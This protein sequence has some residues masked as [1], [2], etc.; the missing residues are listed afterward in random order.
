MLLLLNSLKGMAKRKVQMISIIA[1]ILLSATIYMAMNTAITRV[2]NGYYEYL[3]TQNV[4]HFSFTPKFKNIKD[5]DFKLLTSLT[6][7][8]KQII[9]AYKACYKTECSKEIN[10]YAE[11]IFYKYNKHVFV[12]LDGIKESSEKLD[13]TYELQSSKTFKD[14]KVYTKVV[15]YVDQKI[16]LPYLV[17]GRF[18]KTNSEITILPGFKKANDIKI[19]DELKVNGKNYTVVGTAYL[20][21]HIYPLIS[22]NVPIFT[23][24]TNNIVIMNEEEYKN[25]DLKEELMYSARFN[26]DMTFK[27]R[28]Q[29][30][31]AEDGSLTIV[32]KDENINFN[33]LNI[34]RFIRTDAIQGDL[35]P[36]RVFTEAFLYLLI[37]IASFIVII[38]VKKRIEDEKQQIGILKSLGYNSFNISSSYLLYPIVG[39][40]I[41]SVLG[42]FLGILL[43]PFLINMYI[44]VYNLPIGNAPLNISELMKLIVMPLIILSIVSY[45]TAFLMVRK[46][47]LYLLKEGSNLKVNFLSRLVNKILTPFKFKTRFKYSLAFRSLGKLF[48][49]SAVSFTS[50]LL[51]VLI[52]IGSNLFSSLLDQMFSR[53]DY[54]YIVQYNSYMS[55]EDKN[56]DLVFNSS[57]NIIKINDEK[58]EKEIEISFQG[59]DQKLIYFK[60]TDENDKDLLPNL[61]GNNIIIPSGISEREE[62]KIGDVLTFDINN[63]E[64]NFKV[65]GIAEDYLSDTLYANRKTLSETYGFKDSVYTTKF[66]N[67]KK[68]ESM[69]NLTDEEKLSITNIFNF[70]DLQE[71]I[72]NQIKVFNSVIYVVIAFSSFMALIIVLVIANIVVEENKKN[73]SLMKVLGYKNK[74]I[75]KVILNIYTPFIIVAYL[76]SVPVMTGI[77]KK[78]VS[79]IAGDID[80]YI[81]IKTSPLHVL[82]GLLGMLIAYYIGVSVSKK[83]LNK[84]PLAIALKRE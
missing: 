5:E 20:S 79:L 46:K 82:L 13:F 10:E 18:P 71:N 22:L 43:S 21:D 80:L 81:P 49:V 50:G 15:P 51:I 55:D 8:E 7:E 84:I 65:S 14:E 35:G 31:L 68:Y 39:V 78:I 47:P 32:E 58:L 25:L 34:A 64:I 53:I 70:A 74:D 42:Y 24:K 26:Y 54:N 2:E 27:D 60:V 66:S 62:I 73:I 37:G 76:A 69:T 45:I 16:N 72:E 23:E 75:S 52:L 59:I 36:N 63:Q 6:D 44:S 33:F 77:L 9:E 67:D 40:I 17:E 56:S 57:S 12:N 30:S 1:I 28:M 41:G 4:E 3:E 83:S 38:I 11:M 29:S 61:T 48:I 19:G